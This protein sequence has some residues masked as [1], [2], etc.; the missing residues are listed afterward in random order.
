MA[1]PNTTAIK[2][3]KMVDQFQQLGLKSIINLQTPGTIYIFDRIF[4]FNA[5]YIHPYQIFM[6]VCKSF[7]WV[8]T[9]FWRELYSIRTRSW[10]SY[11]IHYIQ[12]VK[13]SQQKVI[14]GLK[15]P[16][17]LFTTRVFCDLFSFTNE[18]PLSSCQK[19]KQSNFLFL[20]LNLYSYIS[21]Y[22]Y[23]MVFWN[24]WKHHKG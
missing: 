12:F 23:I 17:L 14:Q 11:K 4:I 6:N 2:K 16:F 7:L 15:S 8:F 1:R 22:L 21:M 3:H 13:K 10:F 19:R 5:V 9:N 20:I 24:C 18:C